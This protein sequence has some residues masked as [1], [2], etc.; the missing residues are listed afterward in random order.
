MR[1]Q[2]IHNA[3][4]AHSGEEAVVGRTIKLLQKRG[5]EV[6]LFSRSSEEIPQM[7]F[8]TARAF[9][10]GIHNPTS[11]KRMRAFLHE[12]NPDLVH[13]H[14][15]YPLISPSVLGVCRDEG[16]PIVMTVHNYRLVCP[17]GLHTY[18]GKVCNQCCGGN[19]HWAVLRNCEGNLLKSVG[20]AA[21]N[22]A[23]RK[24]GAYLN[25]V[26][27]YACLTEFQRSRLID[28]G[29]PAERMVVIPNMAED[30]QPPQDQPLG[31]YVGFVGRISPEKSVGTL[32]DAAK[33]L[34]EVSF[35]AAGN[36]DKLPNLKEFAPKNFEFLG[37][38]PSASV[39]AFYQSSRFII[40]C[41]TW[42]E[43]FPMILVEA[44]LHGKPVVCSRIGGLP[45]I[46]DDGK[47][48]LLFEPGNS[49]EL[50]QKI[51]YLWERPEL[52]K[53]MGQAGQE[54]AMREYSSDRYYE[55]LIDLYQ[56]AVEL[57]P[58]GEARSRKHSLP[59]IDTA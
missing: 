59:V 9:L 51:K 25:N 17:S 40:L 18:Q 44:M 43:G 56:R 19:E 47:T 48:G 36:Y 22:W 32:V 13:V 16:V 2:T 3:Y 20:Y 26:T 49:D 6:S 7:R 46:V 42:F 1:I 30:I 27:M 5:H 50:A 38:I 58:G 21:R 57:G 12:T 8:G 41:S 14:N 39:G 35:R 31:D 10:C 34:P 28:E 33:Q 4:G 24:R 29:Y 45:E 37:A 15:V 55:R 23:A 52:C 11:V 54:K 53:Q